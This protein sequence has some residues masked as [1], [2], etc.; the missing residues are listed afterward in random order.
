[1]G[2]VHSTDVTADDEQPPEQKTSVGQ[3]PY[4]VGY[5][6][7]A[8]KAQSEPADFGHPFR[9][10]EVITLRS[11]EKVTVTKIVNHPDLSGRAGHV[12]AHMTTT[13]PWPSQLSLP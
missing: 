9:L 2:G 5:I 3:Y 11:G 8:A 10:Q 13:G 1:L 7:E 4:I 6:D 12:R